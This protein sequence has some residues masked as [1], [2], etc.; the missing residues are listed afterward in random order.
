MDYMFFSALRHVTAPFKLISYDIACQW[1]KRL[2][3][4]ALAAPHGLRTVIDNVTTRYA[5]PKFHAP[6]H[7]PQCQSKFSLNFLR[8]VG[9]TYGEGVES[10]WAH[11]NGTAVSTRE[12]SPAFRHETLNAHF[13][14]WNWLKILGLGSYFAMKLDEAGKQA[15]V[16]DEALQ[17]FEEALSPE[18]V[19]G[20][21][22][23]IDDWDRGSTKKDPYEEPEGGEYGIAY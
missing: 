14:A 5:I 17:S 8:D 21:V 12:M 6:A 18:D 16:H 1:S 19:A 10:I 15:V 4:R 2:P 20:W 9:R 23:W 3:H 13:S 22:I 11:L 7:G